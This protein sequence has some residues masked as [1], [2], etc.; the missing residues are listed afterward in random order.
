[1]IAAALKWADRGFPV[2]PIVPRGKKPL[3]SLVPHGLKEASRD[4][5]VIRDW[6]RCEPK[7]NIG[8]V[9]G[10]GH[11]V[12]D[13]D[14]AGA[15]L[16]FAN[17]SG[18]HGAPKTLTVRTARGYH[19]F[20]ACGAEVPNS[21]G[22]ICPRRRCS[23]RRRLCGRCAFRASQ[24]IDLPGR[25]RPAG[26]R[27]SAMA[28]R[29]CA[30]GTGAAATTIQAR[31][32]QRPPSRRQG[33]RAGANRSPTARKAA[34]IIFATGPATLCANWWRADRSTPAASPMR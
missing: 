31:H 11:F 34:A 29:P 24:R 16:W 1:M 17:A 27:G 26:C 15:V 28:C 25:A 7:A 2:F 33:K 5:A 18:R 22:R 4:N 10:G 32:H 21:A 19:V 13:L 30:A 9:T 14:D 6:W 3:G 8:I 12:I 23:G 20:F